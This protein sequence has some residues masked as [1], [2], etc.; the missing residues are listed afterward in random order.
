M[1]STHRSS[2][3]TLD[4]ERARGSAEDAQDKYKPKSFVRKAVARFK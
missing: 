2:G 4:Q 3:I 1:P